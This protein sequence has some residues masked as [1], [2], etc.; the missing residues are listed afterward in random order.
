MGTHRRSTTQSG[1]VGSRVRHVFALVLALCLATAQ[2]IAH[3]DYVVP[4]NASTSLNGGSISL[5]CTDLIV[6][7]SFSLGSGSVTG[8]RNVIIQ[9]GGNLNGGSGALSLAGNF[10]NSGNFSAGTGSVNFVDMSGCTTTGVGTVSGNNSFYDLS[11]V[12]TS[13]TGKTYAFAAGSTQLINHLFT[14]RGTAAG[15]LQ[16]TSSV[17]GQPAF[18]N[19]PITGAQ[20]MANLGAVDLVAIGVWLAPNLVNLAP[21]NGASAIGWFGVPQTLIVP[22]LSSTAVIALTL[23]LSLIAYRAARRRPATTARHLRP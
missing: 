8:V 5:A 18:I 1:V 7:G 20:S 23:L 15:P 12:T 16:L 9:S 19:L 2:P 17:A 11:F 13:A 21:S 3:A 4:A 6:G 14:V 22:T 10:A